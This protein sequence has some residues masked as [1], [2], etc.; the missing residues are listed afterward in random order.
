MSG[1]KGVFCFFDL[2]A[3]DQTAR[4]VAL[5]TRRPGRAAN[6]P[7][8]QDK[9][10]VRVIT[11][12]EPG[13]NPWRSKPPSST[14]SFPRLHLSPATTQL[15]YTLL[16]PHAPTLRGHL[17]CRLVVV[18]PRHPIHPITSHCEYSLVTLTPRP[19]FTLQPSWQTSLALQ[20]HSGR[21]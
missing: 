7:G 9:T 13:T 19:L 6:P 18:L 10:A 15:P 16:A 21:H 11:G 1:C 17:S 8:T 4:G 12:L 20:S 3:P 5:R 2:E 14:F